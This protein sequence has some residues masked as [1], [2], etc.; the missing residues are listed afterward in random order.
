MNENENLHKKN[1]VFENLPRCMPCIKKR[2]NERQEIK[3][4]LSL[5]YV[6]TESVTKHF[7]II[8]NVV[9]NGWNLEDIKNMRIK[10]DETVAL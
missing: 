4:L 3:R 1:V 8:N 5:G 7:L 9:F 10:T 2:N 6:P